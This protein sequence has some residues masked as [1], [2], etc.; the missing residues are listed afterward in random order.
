MHA[1]KSDIWEWVG[2]VFVLLDCCCC[3][4]NKLQIALW[5]YLAMCSQCCSSVF[6]ETLGL[7]CSWLQELGW[8]GSQQ[9]ARWSR[10]GHVPQ[11][12]PM[13]QMPMWLLVQASSFIWG[14]WSAV[15]S[16]LWNLVF[17]WIHNNKLYLSPCKCQT[18]AA[19]RYSKVFAKL[20][21][22]YTC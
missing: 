9:S 16:V 19:P 10:I 8:M 15:W 22:H 1:L 14:W 18:N 2:F 5:D 17:I 3:F 11:Q 12:D 20:L 13:Q 4:K 6:L 21:L 7:C